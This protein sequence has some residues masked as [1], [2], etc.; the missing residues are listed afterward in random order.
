MFL[1]K[2]CKNILGIS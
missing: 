1:Q 2:T